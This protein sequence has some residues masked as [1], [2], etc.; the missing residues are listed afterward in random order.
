MRSVLLLIPAVMLA[1]TTPPKTATPAPKAATSTQT[2]APAAPAKAPAT[3]TTTAA[4]KPAG[5]GTATGAAAPKP[6]APK[7]VV[8]AAPALTTDDQK[9]VYAI[10]LSIAQ[11]LSSL[12]LSTAEVEIIKRAISDSAAKK[13]AVE[14]NEW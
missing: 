8:A 10:G 9:T 5:P 1:Q 4:P 11:N 3:G 6:A 7:P 12:D 14:L 13:P 2:K